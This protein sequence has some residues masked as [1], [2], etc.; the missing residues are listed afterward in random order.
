VITDIAALGAFLVSVV[1]VI[2]AG[3][4]TYRQL[5]LMQGSNILPIILD[6]FERARSEDF[7][8]AR[9]FVRDDL[10]N[11]Y[12]TTLGISKLPADVRQKVQGVAG[13]FD[14]LAKMVAHGVVDESLI[15]GTYGTI[16]RESWKAVGPY[17]YSE[18]S[19][20]G[21]NTFVY[22]ED[23]AARTHR[24]PPPTVYRELGLLS[25][26]PSPSAIPYESC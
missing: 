8:S 14:D 10:L 19:I 2:I 23:L 24:R 20:H 18:R 25:F 4:S 26:P 13:F 17:A 22:F 7:R 5:K 12:E 6:G 21:S 1:A 9:L 11:Q 16:I 15:I 3:A